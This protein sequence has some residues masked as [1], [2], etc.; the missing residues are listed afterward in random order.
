MYVSLPGLTCCLPDV[1]AGQAWCGGLASLTWQAW[2][3]GK[4]AVVAWQA[5]VAWCGGWQACV[6]SLVWWLASLARRFCTKPQSVASQAA[7]PWARSRIDRKQTEMFQFTAAN[8]GFLGSGEDQFKRGQ[9]K[10]RF[11]KQIC[12]SVAD[13]KNILP[14][15]KNAKHLSPNHHCIE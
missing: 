6:A 4:P 13:P 10:T 15:L 5:G 12:S 1:V 8:V 14:S 7:T 9:I 3:G 11:T 2:C